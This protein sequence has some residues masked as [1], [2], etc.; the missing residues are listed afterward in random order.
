MR[1][2][3]ESPLYQQPSFDAFIYAVFETEEAQA[4][5]SPVPGTE[6]A[7]A[8]QTE[9]RMPSQP[10]DEDRVVLLPPSALAPLAPLAPLARAPIQSPSNP[11]AADE[12]TR[13]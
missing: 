1:T 13:H 3:T 10:P 2:E 4:G 7:A 12:D 8:L 5:E 9:S 11:P 6:L